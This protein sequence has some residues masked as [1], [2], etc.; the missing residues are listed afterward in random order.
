[1]SHSIRKTSLPISL[2]LTYPVILYLQQKNRENWHLIHF[3]CFNNLKKSCIQCNRHTEIAHYT[4]STYLWNMK[5]SW[6]CSDQFYPK[7]TGWKMLLVFSFWLWIVNIYFDLLVVVASFTELKSKIKV[8]MK[9]WITS[10]QTQEDFLL[11]KELFR[12]KYLWKC[13]IIFAYGGTKWQS[14]IILV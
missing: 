8:K 7:R 3:C 6:I 2:A 4:Y 14:T 1:M 11:D 12:K 10:L 9:S 5:F 13:I